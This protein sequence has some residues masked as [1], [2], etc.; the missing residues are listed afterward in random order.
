VADSNDDVN[1]HASMTGDITEAMEKAAVAAEEAEHKL[2]SLGKTGVKVGE[3][4]DEGMDRAKNSTQRARNALG[5]FVPAAT[6]AGNAAAASGAKAAA[7]SLGYTKLANSV[8]GATQATNSSTGGAKKHVSTLEAWAKSADKASKAT[9]GLKSMI[10]LI[11][12]GTILS[13][14][15]AVVGMLVSLGAGAVMAVGRLAPLSGVAGALGPAFF[16]AAAGMAL[17]K[18]S[19]K[20][21]GALLRPLTN[22]FMAM[23]MEISQKMVPGFQAFDREIHDRMI[24]TLH[25]GLVGLAGAFGGAVA[26]VGDMVSGARQVSQ[27]GTLFAGVTPMVGLMG[28]SLG[29]V[30]L[31]LLNLAVAALP[32]TTSMAQGLDRVTTKLDAWSKRMT[33]S[34]KAQAF[35]SRAWN[36]LKT[37]G[38][39]LEDIIIGLFHIFSIA[40]GVARDQLGGGMETA[41]AKFRAWTTSAAGAARITKFFTD[42]VPILRET[43]LLLLAMLHGISGIG[44]NPQVAGLIRQIRTELL[45]ALGALF[46]NL[47]GTSTG[48]FGSALVTAFTQIA[49]ALSKIPLGGLTIIIQAIA[50]LAGG[51]VFL[52]AHVPGLGLLIG[53]AL[54]L[55]TVFGA[56]AKAV[57]SVLGLFAKVEKIMEWSKSIGALGFILRWVVPLFQGLGE[58]ILFVARSLLYAAI[59]NPVGAIIVGLTLL[60]LAFIYA[61]NHYA[62]FRDGVK[63]IGRAVVDAFIWMAQAAAAPFIKLWDIIKGAYNLIAKGWNLIPTIAVPTWV[64]LIGGTNFSLPKMPL[65][66]HG[67]TIEYGTAIV[68]EQGP[69]A[70][71][72]GGQFL[73]MIGTHGPELRTDLPRGGYVVPNLGTLSKFPMLADRL[74]ASVADAVAGAIPGYGALLGR[75][76]AAPAGAHVAV[77]VDTGSAEVV[78]AIRDLTDAVLASARRRDPAVDVDAILRATAAGNRRDAAASRY[79]YSSPRRP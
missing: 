7:G 73:G 43:G 46:H 68:G 27:I 49:L 8:K 2:D 14:G 52:V 45:P 54:T 53:T 63:A 12:W 24:P 1:I 37:D 66:A 10:M 15:Q 35:M 20:D 9:G 50:V 56:G 47:S 62:W 64:P 13:G 58:G 75:G 22:D 26:H 57:G 30:L 44:T 60:V 28:N 16:L 78:G 61:W 34:G 51:I 39:I 3:E 25:T 67:G 74:P 40:G 38:R 33:D 4:L 48:G 29:H 11:K 5:Q 79:T 69:E 32:M 76:S 77:N 65:L 6:A 71:I 31:T 21:I 55:F 17:M 19:G 41:A 36:Q 70:L 23:R 72:K 59:S 18:I 42:S